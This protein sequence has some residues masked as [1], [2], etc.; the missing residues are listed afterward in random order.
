MWRAECL[1]RQLQASSCVIRWEMSPL[2]C[3]GAA[4][5]WWT[6]ESQLPEVF[7]HAWPSALCCKLRVITDRSD[8]QSHSSVL[9]VTQVYFTRTLERKIVKPSAGNIFEKVAFQSIYVQRK[10]QNV[11]RV[12]WC[13]VDKGSQYFNSPPLTCHPIKRTKR[14]VT[15]N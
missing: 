9:P 14:I 1:L 3:G 4:G 5:W 10:T 6:R 13:C 7:P 12:L 8:R 15:F 2:A 11:Y